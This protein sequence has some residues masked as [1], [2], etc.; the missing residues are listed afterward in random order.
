VATGGTLT[1]GSAWSTI[2]VPIALRVLEDAGGPGNL[3]AAQRG[4]IERAL[5]LSDNAAAA[6]LFDGLGQVHGG[7]PGAAAAVTEVLRAA[8]DDATVVST[9]GRDGFSPYGQTDWSLPLQERFV[10]AL[11]GG[12]IGDAPSREYLL[13]LMGR[14]TS[15]TWGLGSVGIPARWKGGW[16]PGVTDGY[17]VRQMGVVEIGGRQVA[18]TIAA[19][20]G[21]GQ[22]TSAQALATEVAK[23]VVARAG[24]AVGS[25]AS[26]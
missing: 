6:A 17:L 15:D 22:F 4:Q 26:C 25:S 5:T 21:D 8:G 9:Q 14:V 3:T 7:V 23:W 10:A 24:R 13:D 2:K 11:A 12:C 20:A 19:R 1:S 18:V 16:G